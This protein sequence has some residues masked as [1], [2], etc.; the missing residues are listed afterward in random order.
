[1]LIHRRREHTIRQNHAIELPVQEAFYESHIGIDEQ[2]STERSIR[3]LKEEL[4]HE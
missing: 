1:M 4:H 3:F 2:F